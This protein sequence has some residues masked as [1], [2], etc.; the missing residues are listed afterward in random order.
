MIHPALTEWVK[1]NTAMIALIA[2]RFYPFGSAP[3]GAP[4]PFL[5][6]F[7]DD[8][9]HVHHEGGSSGL[10]NPRIKFDA[11][12]D[13]RLES[14]TVID[15]LRKE[16]DNFRGIMGT[17]GNAIT[18]RKIVID[19]DREDFVPSTD[20]RETGFYRSSADFLVWFVE[21]V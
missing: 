14:A 11:Q 4:R 13:S 10:A 21:E 2:S 12:S 18:V 7:I 3:I 17:G 6:Y 9:L 15:T 20:G 5:T 8:N 1:A 16:L 19:S